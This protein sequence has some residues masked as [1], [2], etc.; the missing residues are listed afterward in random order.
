VP[1][2]QTCARMD[3]RVIVGCINCVQCQ[4]TTLQNKRSKIGKVKERKKGRTYQPITPPLQ[5]LFRPQ[6]PALVC[7]LLQF[8]FARR[9]FNALSHIAQYLSHTQHAV[10]I[11]AI[12]AKRRVSL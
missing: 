11:E 9:G 6:H 12:V 5:I 1:P 2:R 10:S 7:H 8:L 4:S 3:A